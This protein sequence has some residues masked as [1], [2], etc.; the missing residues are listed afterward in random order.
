MKK[1]INF[2]YALVFISLVIAVPVGMFLF[3]KPVFYFYVGCL[4]GATEY[5]IFRTRN[6]FT[7]WCVANLLSIDQFWQVLLAPILNIGVNTAHKFGNPDETASSVV[8]KNLRETNELRWKVIEFFLSFV[9][10]GGKPHAIPSIEEDEV[11][12]RK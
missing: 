12:S 9:L 4:F 6:P 10:E 11:L 5:F 7:R 1:I 2:I 8:G 3:A